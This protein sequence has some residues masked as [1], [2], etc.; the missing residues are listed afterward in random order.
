M[1]QVKLLEYIRLAFNEIIHNKART[2]LT[3]IGIII[4]IAAVIVIIFVIQGA[5]TFVMSE[6]TKIAPVDLIQFYNKYNPDANRYHARMTYDDI[7]AIKEKLGDEIKAIAPRYGGSAKLRHDGKE[8]DFNWVP[9]TPDYKGIYDLE[10]KNGRFLT[11]LDVDNFHRVIVLGYETAEK[12]FDN[13]DAIGKKVNLKGSTFE[14]VGVLPK[15]YESPIFQVSMNDNRG[16]IPIT[17]LER[18]YGIESNFSLL[19]RAKNENQAFQVQNQVLKLLNNRHGLTQHG[20]PKFR[21][22]NMANDMQMVDIIKMV[23][24][25]LLAGV[26][27]ITLLVAGIGVMNIMLVIVA[28][29]T[30]EIGLRKALGAKRR[31]IL[32]QF[33]IESILLCLV[34]GILG[35]ITGYLGSHAVLNFAQNYIQINIGVPLWATLISLIFTSFVGLFFGIYPALKAAKLDPIEALHYE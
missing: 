8:S 19:V 17:V 9:T 4:G 27:S 35:I 23:L 32:A 25:I 5:E 10:V 18:M 12:L 26:A 11:E 20:R 21:S 7:E 28:E 15:D 33:I 14:V 31:D 22:F 34:G 29:R 3:L 2:F 6:I 24:M 16:F 1:K 13:K 30:R